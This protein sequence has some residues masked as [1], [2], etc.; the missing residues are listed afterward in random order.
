MLLVKGK[1]LSVLQNLSGVE[2]DAEILLQIEDL[3]QKHL[4]VGAI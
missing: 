2:V 1:V 3:F 4:G